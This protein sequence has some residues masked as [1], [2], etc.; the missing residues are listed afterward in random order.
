[1]SF[2]GIEIPINAQYPIRVWYPNVTYS[3]VELQ[4]TPAF[5]RNYDVIQYGNF[6][7]RKEVTTNVW[8]GLENIDLNPKGEA[9]TQAVLDTYSGSAGKTIFTDQELYALVTASGGNITLVYAETIVSSLS[10]QII[11]D[12]NQ[13]TNLAQVV[14]SA[15]K[16]I[17]AYDM[18]S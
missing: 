7:L 12:G 17:W 6:K 18:V 11:A 8:R 2:S 3:G 14:T 13:N 10:A 1:M 4:N 15:G 5:Q 16:L 9:T